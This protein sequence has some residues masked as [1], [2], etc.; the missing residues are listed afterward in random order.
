MLR[1]FQ[2]IAANLPVEGGGVQLRVVQDL[3]PDPLPDPDL[4]LHDS[5]H[6]ELGLP[7]NG[8]GVG[9]K[10]AEDPGAVFGGMPL[11][12]K[13]GDDVVELFLVDISIS[14]K[15]KST[16]LGF[17]MHLFEKWGQKST[18]IWLDQAEILFI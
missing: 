10:P 2:S 5:C 9:R 14:L 1:L 15:V 13:P 8:P 4:G 17:V 11:V 3:A 7:E 12:H 18:L 6:Q 16:K